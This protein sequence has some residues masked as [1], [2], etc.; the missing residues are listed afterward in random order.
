LHGDRKTQEIQEKMDRKSLTVALLATSLLAPLAHAQTLRIGMNNDPDVLDPTFSR[1]FVGTV[2]LTGLCDKLVD[3]DQHLN[4]VPGLATSYEWADSKTVVFHLRPNVLF[5]DGEKMDAAA[6][7]YTL[8]RDLSAQGSFRRSEISAMDHVEVVDPLTVRVVLKQ[9]SSPFIAALTDR[10]GMMVS[11]KA[12][13]AEGKDF[14]LH[15]VC[16]GP[17]QF[18]ERV[19]QDHITLDRFPKYWNAAAVHFDRVIYRPMTDSSV[20]L[21]NLQANA[22]DLADI[23]PTDA[24]TV[25]RDPTLM[26][27]M[28]NGLG[29]GALTFNVAA[30]TPLGRDPRIRRA[31]DLSIDRTALIQ[32]VYNGMYAPNVQAVAAD[33]PLHVDS[34]K[35]PTRDV[36]AAR[37]LLAQAGVP[38]PLHVQLVVANNPQA[39]Q[40]AEVLQSM[41]R[42]SGIDLQV[43]AMDFGT[44][45]G[46]LMRGEYEMTFGGWS[47]L[48]DADSNLWTFLHTG[49]PL[50]VS[51]YSNAKV[52]DALDRARLTT[53]VAA[54]RAAYAD[55]WQQERQDLPMSYLWN[56]AYIYGHN[57]KVKGFQ[58]YPDGLLRLQ[59]V[60]L[61]N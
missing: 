54:R 29:Y 14:A 35:S 15:P 39:L 34:V 10:A 30:N 24:E 52:D 50:N 33:S 2:V 7:K 55:L 20:R 41:L 59:G 19:A 8:D 61:S 45:L 37:A 49:G 57:K 17:F 32:V 40:V 23:V 53:D 43:N 26:L 22:V 28:A 12:A 13:E 51:R 16:A 6:V 18:N 48:L 5:Q 56:P 21:A 11:P 44:S 3:F 60:S 58:A 47:G 38:L 42:D 9:P 25:K 27:S 1:T 46:V 31:I 36:A 4:I